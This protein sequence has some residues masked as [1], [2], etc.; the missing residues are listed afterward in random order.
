MM[1]MPTHLMDL[2]MHLFPFLF[3]L[4]NLQLPT[5]FKSLSISPPHW[6]LCSQRIPTEGGIIKSYCL[7]IITPSFPPST[8]TFLELCIGSLELPNAF[9]IC[10][11]VFP[12]SSFCPHRCSVGE[13]QVLR[14]S[15]RLRVIFAFKQLWKLARDALSRLAQETNKS[16]SSWVCFRD[17]NGGAYTFL[18]C[19]KTLIPISSAKGEN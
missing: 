6:H 8:L 12:P 11:D 3:L 10:L 18:M 14:H 9:V 5:D 2:T 13:P 1:L 19:K 17:M 7:C 16:Q 4:S 15:D